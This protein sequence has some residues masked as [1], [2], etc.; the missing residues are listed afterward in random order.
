MWRV[1]FLS[2]KA[3][4]QRSDDPGAAFD[5]GQ[6]FVLPTITGQ[7]FDLGSP[8]TVHSS[9]VPGV[10]GSASLQAQGGSKKQQA[11][12][13][14]AQYDE[15]RAS[16]AHTSPAGGVG[17]GANPWGRWGQAGAA[18]SLASALG[19]LGGP[20][21]DG[22][23]IMAKMLADPIQAHE[24]KKFLAA[25][26]T[27]AVES[28][29]FPPVQ[30]RSDVVRYHIKD[31]APR[32]FEV[33]LDTFAVGLDPAGG[34]KYLVS[35]DELS[36]ATEPFYYKIEK[37]GS[38]ATIFHDEGIATAAFDELSL[39]MRFAVGR[40]ADKRPTVEKVRGYVL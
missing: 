4:I 14:L 37:L 9:G 19:A 27:L 22:E 25:Q 8:A 3:R 28:A 35:A 26:L 15:A 39:R 23:A 38:L 30:G 6:P 1:V 12:G 36:F 18:S 20:E 24:F 7:R 10:A 16:I 33:P 31:L 11:M 2:L 13:M 34:G 5:L 40:D 29:E 17:G 21:A 32:F